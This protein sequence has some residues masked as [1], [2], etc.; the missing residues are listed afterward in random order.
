[1]KNNLISENQLQLRLFLY[2]TISVFYISFMSFYAPLGTNWLEWHF[3]RI[4]NFSEYLRINGYLSNFGFSIWS[5]CSE[6]SLNAE[7]WKNN[8]YLTINFITV[9]PY[10]II[11]DLFGN[12]SL[13]FYGNLLDKIIIIFTGCLIAELYLK[14]LKSRSN[15]YNLIIS[16]TIFSFFLINPWTYK[17]LIAGWW[18]IYFIAFFLFGIL[19]ILEKREKLGLFFLFLAGCFDYQSS[20]GLILFY[21]LLKLF[22]NIKDKNFNLQEYFPSVRNNSINYKFLISL[23][24]PVIIFLSLRFLISADLENNSGSSLL[25]RIG[26]SGD[27][28]HNGGILGALQFLGGNRITLCLEGLSSDLNSM[29]LNT[30]IEIFNCSLS[31]LSMILISLLSFYGLFIIYKNEKKFFNLI[32]LP[33]L[34]LLLSYTFILQQSS[35]VHLMGYSYFFSI[36]FSF[37]ITNLLFQ[38]IKKNKYSLAINIIALPI[39]FG[40]LIL[41]IRVSMLT[42]PNG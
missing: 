32:I 8:I 12:D 11:N 18:I 25:T 9:F 14:F 31:I 10:V 4:Y 23:T 42:G 30:K 35:S 38:I 29:N 6:C 28:I 40:I 1:M 20:T 2:F 26:I 3:L 13:R 34:F 36:L 37:G 27:D 19:L 15:L 5:K 41:F 21:I 24:L 16:V 33:I 22:T 39:I 7:D 17:M